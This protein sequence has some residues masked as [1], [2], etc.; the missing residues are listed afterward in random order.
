[1][2]KA[3]S[4]ALWVC[5][6]L[7]L[8]GSIGC[9][10]AAPSFIKDLFAVDDTSYKAQYG[11]TPTQ[12]V[13]ELRALAVNAGSLSPQQQGFAAEKLGAEVETEGDPMIRRELVATLG[14]FA[15]QQSVPALHAAM[16]DP[17]A[18][19]RAAGCEA[20]AQ[21]TTEE[22]YAV[23]AHTMS[24]DSNAEVRQAAT[25]ALANF[26]SPD[27]MRTLASALDDK[28]PATQLLAMRSLE[29][30]TGQN[31]G[32]SVTKWREFVTGNY[33]PPINMDKIY[34][35]SGSE[36]IANQPDDNDTWR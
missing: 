34:S 4:K 24:T 13:E 15:G 21:R 5:V 28:D 11:Q 17:E 3:S 10:S 8:S 1:M 22:S 36:I 2:Q 9:Q 26:K 35:P 30:A 19:V 20:W 33:G 6:L 16:T 31:L 23:L 14:A 18:V 29:S 32:N 12:R 7:T 25:K 27:A